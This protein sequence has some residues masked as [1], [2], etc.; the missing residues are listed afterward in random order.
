MALIEHLEREG[1]R[2]FLEETFRYVLEV[3]KEDRHRHL[4]SSGDDLRAWLATGG[5][6]RV[7]HRLEEQMTRRGL[8]PSRQAEVKE[9]IEALVRENRAPLLEL[10]AAGIIP[11]QERDGA[12]GVTAADVREC[13]DRLM[14]G[15]RPFEEWMY[16]HGHSDEEI[17]EIYGVID[18]WLV[19]H[20][21]IDKPGPMPRRH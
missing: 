19:Q 4:G 5:V 16:A 6:G 15:E 13:L 8:P 14:K 17:A 11:G 10:T 3:L 7:R 21:I 2:E 20:G 9:V 12:G 18:R 1:W